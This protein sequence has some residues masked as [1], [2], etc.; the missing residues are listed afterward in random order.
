MVP[1][2]SLEESDA[3][4][5]CDVCLSASQMAWVCGTYSRCLQGCDRVYCGYVLVV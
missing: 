4:H 5:V 2:D 1:R 3:C